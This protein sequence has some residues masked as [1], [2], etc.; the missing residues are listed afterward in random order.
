MA[1]MTAAGATQ[2]DVKF[3]L[4]GY[5]IPGARTF[6]AGHPTLKFKFLDKGAFNV[7][8]LGQVHMV[9]SVH[10]AGFSGEAKVGRSANFDTSQ[11]RSPP[12]HI[13]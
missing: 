12:I 6:P 9:S 3:F 13:S 5:R 1:E 8:C 7:R 2:G 4:G 11:I 10:A